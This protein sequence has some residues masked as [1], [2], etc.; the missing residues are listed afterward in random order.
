MVAKIRV[1]DG[2]MGDPRPVYLSLEGDDLGYFDLELDDDPTGPSGPSDG[3]SADGLLA[4]GAQA[5]PVLTAR[6]VTTEVP[7]D[8]EHR[9]LMLS[10]GIYTFK[11]RATELINGELPAEWSE[12]DVTIVVT[13]VDDQVPEFNEDYFHINVSEDIGKACVALSLLFVEHTLRL[14]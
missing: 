6:L 7:I 1:R 3:Q 12:S 8:R 2:D 10:G 13:D 5:G 11:V 9:D 14:P 4:G